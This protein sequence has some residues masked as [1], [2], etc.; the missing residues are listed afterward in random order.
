MDFLH[1][2]NAATG[3]RVSNKSPTQGCVLR[4][5]K[6]VVRVCVGERVRSMCTHG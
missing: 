4:L 1:V 5:L 6:A 2:W 3:A